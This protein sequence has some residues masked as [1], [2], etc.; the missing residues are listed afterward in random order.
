MLIVFGSNEPQQ[1][2]VFGEVFLQL[3]QHLAVRSGSANFGGY[4]LDQLLASFTLQA[5]TSSHR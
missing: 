2:A 5:A 4:H 1:R 3:L